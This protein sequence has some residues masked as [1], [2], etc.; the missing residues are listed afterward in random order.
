MATVG[1]AE[2]GIDEANVSGDPIFRLTDVSYSYREGEEAVCGAT[3][4]VSAGETVA[5]LGANG[6]GKST[7]LRLMAG[8]LF[9]KS[10]SVE[11][12]GKPLT[13]AGMRDAASARLFRRRVG[14]LFQNAEAQLFCPTVR[15]DILFGPRQMGLA[16]DELAHRLGEI[17]ALF[18]LKRL[19]ERAPYEL[20][21]GE[22]RKARGHGTR[23]ATSRCQ[24]IC[25]ELSRTTG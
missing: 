11:A 12:W 24:D 18:G 4:A 22:Q 10:G 8:I 23:R 19:L 1:P 9:A 25:E 21:T 20:S 6:C 13:E 5:I 16:D 7:L 3:L 17:T 15:D 14:Y 2:S